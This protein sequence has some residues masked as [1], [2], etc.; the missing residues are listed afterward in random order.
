MIKD[1]SEKPKTDHIVIDLTGPEGNAFVLMGYARRWSKQLGLDPDQVLAEMQSG[2]YD[3]LL[4]VM[5]DYFGDYI[6]MYR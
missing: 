3:H 1:I 4:S 5:E 2:D 6:V